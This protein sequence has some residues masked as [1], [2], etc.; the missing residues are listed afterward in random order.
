M[1]SQYMKGNCLNCNRELPQTE[2]K[3]ERKFC[4]NKG[5]CKGEY[6]RKQ[7]KKQ[8][9]VTFT[10]FQE[11]KSKF[12]EVVAENERLQ[13]EVRKAAFGI[14]T[15]VPSETKPDYTNNLK[16]I[17]DNGIDTH[18]L[19]VPVEI[20]PITTPKKER[21]VDKLADMKRNEAGALET[22]NGALS[23]DIGEPEIDNSEIERQIAAIKAEKIP[24]ERDTP[25]GRVVWQ[26]DQ[27]KRIAELKKLLK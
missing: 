9:M 25:R 1:S 11:L 16:N 7:G 23:A 17:N 15:V 26:A 14:K 22:S 13:D 6:R 19:I 21:A 4:D 3:R 2:G 20:S 24:K 12:D 10:S 18:N 27:S 5:K 8:K